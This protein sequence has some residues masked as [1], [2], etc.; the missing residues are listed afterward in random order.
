MLDIIL[1]DACFTSDCRLL[2][3]ISLIQNCVL[4]LPP[5]GTSLCTENSVSTVGGELRFAP[6]S[7][8]F[9]YAAHG[10]VYN[11]SLLAIQ[12]IL[13]LRRLGIPYCSCIR[14]YNKTASSNCCGLLPKKVG[15]P[16]FRGL[17]NYGDCAVR[18]SQCVAEGVESLFMDCLTTEDEDSM[19]LRN[20]GIH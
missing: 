18:L 8:M 17:V 12:I 11:Y 16:W 2:L 7:K 19:F 15:H 14:A 13:Q 20:V 3:F 10:H 4:L 1:S 9:C 5:L 6:R